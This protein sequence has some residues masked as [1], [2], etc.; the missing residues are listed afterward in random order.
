MDAFLQANYKRLKCKSLFNE[1]SIRA[2]CAP[3]FSRV[4]FGERSL[5]TRHH[6]VSFFSLSFCIG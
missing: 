6:N 4:G 2:A 1:E 3:Y 5:C